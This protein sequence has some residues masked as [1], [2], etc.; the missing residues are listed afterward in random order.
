MFLEALPI[1]KNDIVISVLGIYEKF[2]DYSFNRELRKQTLCVNEIKYSVKDT[3]EYLQ[4]ALEVA[5]K[6]MELDK[7]F[8]R[9]DDEDLK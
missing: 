3:K 8:V 9:A 6:M 1:V 7:V 4:Y 5:A 2:E